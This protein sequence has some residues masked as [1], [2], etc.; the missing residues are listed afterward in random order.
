MTTPPRG[1]LWWVF[2]VAA[3]LIAG[4]DGDQPVVLPSMTGWS[5]GPRTARHPGGA[6]RR[7]RAPASHGCRCGN[8]HT[9]STPLRCSSAGCGRCG[10]SDAGRSP[11]CCCAPRFDRSRGRSAD[12][13]RPV[14]VGS[15]GGALLCAAAGGLGYL[16]VYRHDRAVERRA[17]DRRAGAADRRTDAE[18]RHG[19][20]AAR[21]RARAVAGHRRLPAAAD[22]PAGGRAEG[23][24]TAN[25]YWAVSSAVLPRR[26]RIRRRCC[27]RCRASAAA[28]PNDLRFIT[29]T[30]RVDFAEVRGRPVAGREPDCAEASRTCGRRPMSPRRRSYDT[31]A[32]PD[33]FER[34]YPNRLGGGDCRSS[35]R[36]RRARLRGRDRSAAP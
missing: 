8:S 9:C 16:A 23:R 24:V 17:P 33:Y 1:W 30:V 20:S 32:Q 14:A 19:H 35:R 34:R 31:R 3:A 6:A 21:L 22:R 18:L 36:G 15:G 5:H 25:E 26:P 28:D 13:R 27:W 10:T 29:A 11:T 4:G 7:C 12:M 2:T